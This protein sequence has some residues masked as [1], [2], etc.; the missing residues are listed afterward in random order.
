MTTQTGVSLEHL[1]MNEDPI[2]CMLDRMEIR[3][4][5]TGSEVARLYPIGRDWIDGKEGRD[6]TSE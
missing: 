1:L 6:L 2:R 4:L 3:E 5:K